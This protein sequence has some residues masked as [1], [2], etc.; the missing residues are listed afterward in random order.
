M[1][2]MQVTCGNC[3]GCGYVNQK[4]IPNNDGKTMR[5][6]EDICNECNGKGYT[7]YAVFSIEE[8]EAILKHCGLDGSV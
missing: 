7:E 2:R 5:I 1:K 3:A 6:E 8:A 4:F